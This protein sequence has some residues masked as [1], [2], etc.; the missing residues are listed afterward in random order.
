MF[1]RKRKIHGKER[2]YLE[3]SIRML[4]G[5]IKKISVYFKDY[6]NNIEKYKEKIIIKIKE[7]QIEYAA[8]IYKRDNLFTEETIKK[9]EEAKLGYKQIIKKLTKNQLKDVID[10][11]AVN[12]TYESNAIEGNSLTLKDVAFVLKEKKV[13][14]G[15]DLRE[16]YE[17]TNTK[18]ALELI[19]NNKIR[20]NK[21]DIIKLHRILVKNT[22]V[23]FGF[24]KIPNE[25]LGRNVKT[26]PPEHVEK[27]IENLIEQYHK[28][29]NIHPLQKAISFHGKF[30]KIHPFDDGNGRTGRLLTNI[31][32]IEKGYPPLIIRKTQRIAYFKALDS[33]DNGYEDKLKRFFIEKF[34]NTYEKFFLI[35]I[36]YL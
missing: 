3:H 27:E 5:E 26:T 11:F 33:F 2:Y 22:G 24:K 18:E 34:K 23:E 36:K 10:R 20:I 25:L 30:E 4:D 12:F 16:I 13:L 7:K 1:T 6:P 9:I 15:K 8:K 28:E 14:A 32:L 29:N 35:Y 21:E 31:I 17:T 19:F